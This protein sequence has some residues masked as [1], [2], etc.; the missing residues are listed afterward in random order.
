MSSLVEELQRGALD[1]STDI[2]ELLRK[3]YA[4]ATKLKLEQF[5][6]WCEF[7]LNGYP[8]GQE[9]PAYRESAGTI[10]A[11]NPYVGAAIPIIFTN[12][13]ETQKSWSLHKDR[14]PVSTTQ[15]LLRTDGNM[16]Q[17][18]LSP[19]MQMHLMRGTNTEFESALQI[20]RGALVKLVDGVRN[21]ILEW[22][23]RLEADGI[24]GDGLSF[25]PVEKEIAHDHSA[26][27]QTAVNY[28]TI[29]SMNHSSIQQSSPNAR[30]RRA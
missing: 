18:S 16:F 5:K 7:E 3:A 9:V 15:D 8:A 17:V 29:G 1:N 19:Q 22:S 14:S 12:D 28:I 30:Q 26:E 25:T 4:V 10:R 27:L 6:S 23:L 20:G 2:T 21:T 11:W 24:V 13:P